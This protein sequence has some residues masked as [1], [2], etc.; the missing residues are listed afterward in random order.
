MTMIRRI[1]PGDPLD[2]KC[3]VQSQS[4]WYQ[5]GS[6]PGSSTLDSNTVHIPGVHN[7]NLP[8]TIT[9]PD[10]SIFEPQIPSKVNGFF[11]QHSHSEAPSMES[12]ASDPI[13]F[14]DSYF[15]YYPDDEFWN[16]FAED[17][18][19]ETDSAMDSINTG[20]ENFPTSDID[21]TIFQS[22]EPSSDDARL[23]AELFED[24]E[25]PDSR[26]FLGQG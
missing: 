14:E 19:P 11:I 15:L 8:D 4:K 5:P 18:R 20:Q 9:V 25:E 7:P 1:C 6:R 12:G 2:I 10:F 24:G 22:P 16:S 17:P 3:C 21:P 26:D 13:P 23:A